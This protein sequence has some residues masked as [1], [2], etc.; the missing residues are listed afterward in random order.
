MHLEII[1]KTF[2]CRYKTNKKLFTEK[3]KENIL[4]S[5]DHLYDEP[6]TDD[7]HYICFKPYDPDVHDHVQEL[8]MK[9]TMITEN[10]SQGISWVQPD[11]LQPFTKDE[12][13]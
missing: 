12:T 8:M 2:I 1:N 9:T 4:A 6:P 3:V 13:S 7:K 11:S 5:I 10:V